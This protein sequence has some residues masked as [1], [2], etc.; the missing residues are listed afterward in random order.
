MRSTISSYLTLKRY[1]GTGDPIATKILPATHDRWPQVADKSGGATEQCSTKNC[2]PSARNC[3]AS[4]RTE[5]LCVIDRVD[6]A[7]ER[8]PGGTT[9][10]SST[11]LHHR[12]K[13]STGVGAT[14]TICC[15]LWGE[16]HVVGERP[17]TFIIRLLQLGSQA[18]GLLQ[19]G[20]ERVELRQ[21]DAPFM[22]DT[23]PATSGVSVPTAGRATLILHRRLLH[24][25]LI[26]H[27]PS[28]S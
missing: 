19:C 13:H 23:R 12:L 25:R 3:G 17:P 27:P 7:L 6:R 22:V 18:R 26:L 16:Q 11:V 8:T 21:A 2:G 5:D 24:C 15:R 4:K 9:T 14:C 28:S 20:T 1:R 10:C